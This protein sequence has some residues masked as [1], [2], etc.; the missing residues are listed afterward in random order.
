MLVFGENNSRRLSHF[1]Q[2]YI[3]W[4]FDQISRNYNQINYRNTWFVKV[5]IILIMIA[6][7]F[8]FNVFFEKDTHLN[9]VQWFNA[10]RIYFVFFKNWRQYNTL[11]EEVRVT[12]IVQQ[13]KIIQIWLLF[14]CHHLGFDL[15]G[16]NLRFTTRFSLLNFF[17]IMGLF[18]TR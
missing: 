8:F 11:I 18:A 5:T 2:T 1:L 9:A 16:C 7:V 13:Q 4:K 12:L 10:I 3:F 6:Q 15:I 17:V 14:N